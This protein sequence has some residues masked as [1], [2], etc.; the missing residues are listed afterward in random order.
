MGCLL[1]L[2]QWVKDSHVRGKR[3]SPFVNPDLLS[4][5][6]TVGSMCIASFDGFINMQTN[7]GI[8]QSL[9]RVMGMLRCGVPK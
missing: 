3:P 5:G 4:A 9:L 8:T 2:L 7:I 6:L 1:D